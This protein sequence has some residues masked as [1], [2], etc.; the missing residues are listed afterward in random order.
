M[1]TLLLAGVLLLAPATPEP[2]AAPTTSA[3]ATLPAHNGVIVAVQPGRPFELAGQDEAGAALGKRYA[4][5]SATVA[6]AAEPIDRAQAHLALANWLLAVPAGRPATQWLIGLD[7]PADRDVL[8]WA[9]EQAGAQLGDARAALDRIADKTDAGMQRRVRSYRSAADTL[10]AFVALYEAGVERDPDARRP[11]AAEAALELAIARESDDPGLAACALLWQ[12]YAWELAGRHER[13]MLSLPESWEAPRQWP[14]D[15]MARLLRC[16]LIG[17][18]KQ[19]AAALSLTL[20]I[21]GMLRE[22]LA[23][24]AP[25]QVAACR[26][27]VRKLAWQLSQSWLND[28]RAEGAPAAA[29]ERLSELSEDLGAETGAAAFH[30]AEAIPILVLPPDTPLPQTQPASAPATSGRD[31]PHDETSPSTAPA[32]AEPGTRTAPG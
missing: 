26:A 14:Y 27:L 6:A 22:W 13:A 21:D 15:F 2:D 19:Y 5:L 3:P 17:E 12:S 16:R 25:D 29:I 18:R 4:E 23:S 20:G 8:H 32:D 10:A 1:N 28:L 24:I 30:L 11:R 7:Q 31:S 9:A